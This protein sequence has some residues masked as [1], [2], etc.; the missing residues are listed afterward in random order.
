MSDYT[1][2]LEGGLGGGLIGEDGVGAGWYSSGAGG[3]SQ[4]S[5]GHAGCYNY[6]YCGT[7]GQFLQGGNGN[8]YPF[9]GSGGGGKSYNIQL[10][11]AIMI[12]NNAI[13]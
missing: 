11:F 1:S 9:G 10:I 6:N 8:S 4:V 12:L 13:P 7:S 3:G 2:K 5:G